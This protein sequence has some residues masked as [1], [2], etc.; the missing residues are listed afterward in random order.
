MVE[1]RSELFGAGVHPTACAPAVTALLG[2]DTVNKIFLA[3][4]Y[5]PAN[6]PLAADIARLIESHGL[7]PITGKILGGANIPEAVKARIRGSDAVISLLTPENKP[8][9]AKWKPGGWPRD[10]LVAARGR[11]QRAIAIVERNAELDGMIKGDQYIEVDRAA[12]CSAMIEL[13]ETIA[14]WKA[15]AGRAIDLRLVPDAAATMASTD[16][17]KC[18]YR[19]IDQNAKAGPWQEDSARTRPGGVFL[20]VPGVRNNE[21]IEVQIMD[22]QVT[23]WRSPEAPPS[24]H[25]ELKSLP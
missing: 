9:K 24:Y 23:R 1:L 21:Q 6:E 11:G 2:R 14:L 16:G 13:S 19:I 22:G 8:R 7:L 25:V 20:V 3:Y 17:V 4:S 10:E 5:R 18:R 15:E 12:P